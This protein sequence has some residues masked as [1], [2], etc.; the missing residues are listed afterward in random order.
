MRKPKQKKEYVYMGIKMKS[1]DEV[2]FAHYLELQRIE[3]KIYKWQYE[4]FAL[5]IAPNLSI[6]RYKN[7]KPKRTYTPDFV[8]TPYNPSKVIWTYPDPRDIMKR[9]YE[10]KGWT[11]YREKGIKV[12]EA[13]ANLYI[14]DY[15]FFL[16]EY[17]GKKLTITEYR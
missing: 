8:V 1:D 5:D 6:M 4:P 9:I 11:P 14:R 16:A 13:A 2:K 10:V 17:K 7:G 3:G 15:N 12:F